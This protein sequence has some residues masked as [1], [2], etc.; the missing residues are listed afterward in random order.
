[1]LPSPWKTVPLHR[2]AEVR[3]GI[4]KGKTGLKDPVELPYLR[5][6]NVQDGRIDLTEVKTIQVERAQIDRYSLRKGDIL[7]TEGGDFDKLGRGAVWQGQIQ[8]C[9]HQ[10]HIF[11]VRPD[12]E[13][14]EPAFLSA[15]AG[16]QYGR[17]YFLSCAKRSTNLA[18][19][20]SS[21]LK[22]F[23]ILLPSLNEQRGI[24][25]ILATWDQAITTTERLLANSSK[26]RNI[27]A[28][29]LLT[30]KRRLA[31]FRTQ[32]PCQSTPNGFI[33]SDWA[34]RQVQEIATEINMKL[35]DDV[36]HKV[37][38]CTKHNGL[39]DSLTYFNKQ[40]FSLDTSTYKVA[41]RNCFVY[42]TNHIEEG[43][44]GYQDLYDFGLVSPMY[45]V[46]TTKGHVNDGYLYRLLKTEHYRQIFAA[47]TNASVDRRGS[48]RWNEFKKLRV[49]VPSTDE[50][51]AI[52]TLL[53]L[54]EHEMDVLK[55]QLQSLRE[56]KASLMAQL[57]TGRRRVRLPMGQRASAS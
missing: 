23:P 34:F 51:Q 14:V 55:L 24:A 30:G 54:S 39:V 43:S 27:L 42:A 25:N 22:E 41:P 28:H 40:V 8:P 1:M 13:H 48:L 37:L 18:S 35:G 29:Q 7:M 16:S 4:A 19:I 52:A 10:N 53:S 33:P 31:R 15:L 2:V 17:S 47:A 21:Q 3:T 9:L 45:T 57:L 46:F 56:E 44:I 11:A 12:V 36:P 20:N 49:P 26:Q 5:V 38:S 50:Q 32:Q 6:A